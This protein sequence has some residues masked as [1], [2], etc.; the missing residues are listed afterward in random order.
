[1]SEMHKWCI[2]P[3]IICVWEHNWLHDD[4]YC[5]Y[6]D[7][8]IDT[9][10][11]RVNGRWHLIWW[12]K[13]PPKVKNLLWLICRNYLS[14]LVRRSYWGVNC[15]SKCAL[16]DDGVEDSLH[17]FSYAE[18]AYNVGKSVWLWTVVQQNLNSNS[19][20]VPYRRKHV[21]NSAEYKLDQMA[22]FAVT[23]WSMWKQRNK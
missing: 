3:G 10:N 6:I 11:L 19:T 23:I 4:T 14:S 2:G 8:T 12:T 18:I 7:E 21:H 15:P 20:N 5:F 13:I 17:I 1:V 22:I 9:D 16:C